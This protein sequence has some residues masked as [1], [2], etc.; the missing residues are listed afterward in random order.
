MKRVGR[1]EEPEILRT[2]RA[3]NPAGTWDEFKGLPGSGAVFESL[4]AAQGYLCGYCEIE[5][6]G[7]LYG[8]VEHFEPKS[9]SAGDRNFNLEFE[10]LIACCE[11]GTVPWNRERTEEPISENM[12]CGALKSDR[13]P[14]AKML[15][16]R[17]LPARPCLW[18]TVQGKLFVD[19]QAC[20]EAGVDAVIAESTLTF[21][22]LNRRV[23]LRLR[24]TLVAELDDEA[25]RG[26]AD[27]TEILARIL[28]V[29]ERNLLPDPDVKLSRF[30]STIRAWA[31]PQIE[32]FI[33][34]NAA[35]IPGLS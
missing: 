18:R 5:L 13:T 3:A 16:P 29:A 1:G 33:L 23:L 14:Q 19:I 35:R 2:F 30:W 25:I 24:E 20:L 12:H 34:A 26:A 9:S 7:R 11:G 32:P 15:D 17:S 27:D 10:N 8:Q 22:G 4:A 31:G 28:T 6:V 21:L